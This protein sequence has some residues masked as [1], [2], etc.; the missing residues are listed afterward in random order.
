MIEENKLINAI[1][2]PEITL[3]PSL[4]QYCDL[5]SNT[6]EFFFKNKQ[7][8]SNNP[9]KGFLLEG[10][11][12]TGKTEIVKQAAR[13]LDRRMHN[14]FFI[15]IDG[16]DIASPRWGDAEQKLRNIF[17]SINELKRTKSENAKLVILFDDIESLMI[18]RGASL[19]KEWHYSINSI[20]FHEIDK[21]N[22]TETILLGT[23]NRI[24]LV[25]EAIQSRLFV[26]NIPPIDIKELSLIV[27]DILKSSGIA[28]EDVER[29][30][31]MVMSSLKAMKRPT[32]RDA[33]KLTVVESIKD[34]VWR[35]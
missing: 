34:G 9:F 6:C 22:P 1:S 18:S 28:S 25:D 29:I 3:L 26:L 24:D 27:M 16:A 11:P 17:N 30:H 5:I 7:P 13:K 12:G 14:V 2:L 21:L 31:N 35:I 8:I 15:I 20:L 32:I 4:Q 19:A 10:D 23:T 33:Q